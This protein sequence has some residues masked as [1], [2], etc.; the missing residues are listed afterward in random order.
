MAQ[1]ILTVSS[2]YSFTA[3]YAFGDSL[4]D[5][6]RNAAGSKYY[7]GRYSNGPLWIEYLS[8]SLGIAYNASNN[9]AYAGDGTSALSMQVSEMPVSTNFPTS[10]FAI[11]SGAVD[12]ALADSATNDA[13]WAAVITNAVMNITNTVTTLYNSGARTVLL[14]NLPNLTEVP[15]YLSL[16]A[17]ASNYLE[18]KVLL[19]NNSL[20]TA[21][22]GLVQAFPG[23]TAAV[24]DVNQV[25]TTVY[26]SPTAY[27]F[28]V[29]SV[30]A[31]YDTDLMDKS[32]AGPG[33][34][35]FYWD[36]ANPTTKFHAILGQSAYDAVSGS[37]PPVSLSVARTG[38]SL[39]LIVNN[40]STNQAYSIQVS[41]NLSTWTNYL[42]FTPT[43]TSRTVAVTNT[44]P[45][46]RLFRVAY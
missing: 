18:S 29:V 36:N 25:W 11:C 12:F 41:T 15:A 5:T 16:P 27:G 20:A 42:T 32:F 35:Y 45:Q 4:T 30:G 31:L 17:F 1:L 21:A 24:L 13:Q 23:L 46:A 37:P 40:L 39:S 28:T 14:L 3:L 19:F 26:D 9:H 34:D 7:D 22:A 8:A 10:L 38:A 2:A 44:Q 43:G 33:A 6:G